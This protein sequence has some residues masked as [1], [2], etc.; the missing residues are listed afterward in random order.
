MRGGVLAWVLVW[1]VLGY[2][3]Y[4]T[5]YGALGSLGSR[6][7]DAQSV[8][9]PVMIVM[10][11][12]Y[13]ASLTMIAQPTSAPARAIS[14]FPLTAPMAM[15]GRIALGAAAWWEPVVATALALAT[16]AA[17]VQFAGRVYASAIL[18]S[19]PRLSL[20]DA[21]RSASAPGPSAAKAGARIK[22]WP[23]RTRG[24]ARGRAVMTRTDLTS[25]RLLV[26]VLTGIG[27]VL[28]A[29]VGMFTRDVILGVIG[30]AGFIAL[31]VQ[32]VKLWT[33]RSG[34]PLS[35]Q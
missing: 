32:M 16:T 19:G 21:W 26:A 6:V 11:V 2:L 24:M 25:H 18:H 5:L 31:A 30:G 7:E 17:L 12:G 3:L 27:V 1:F 15:P 20:R 33:G 23:R 9:G 35:H 13:V 10:A 29:A 8:A 34:P 4:A 14:Y 28:G 22:V